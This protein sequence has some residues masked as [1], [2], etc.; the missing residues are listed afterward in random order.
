MSRKFNIEDFEKKFVKTEGC[1]E[2]S[3]TK[4]SKKRFDTAC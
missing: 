3:A 4:N 1:W 2:W